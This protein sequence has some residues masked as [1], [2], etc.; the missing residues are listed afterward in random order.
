MPQ[1]SR[2][3]LKKEAEEKLLESL[4][5]LFSAVSNKEEMREFLTALMTETEKLMLAKRVGVIVLIY[6]G[7]NDTQIAKILNLTRITVSKIRYFYESRGLK[8]YNIMLGKLKQKERLENLKE[9]LISI[10]K[11][12]MEMT[13]YRV[14]PPRMEGS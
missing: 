8:G 3:K 12:G 2:I 4:D 14:K 5:H 9:G 1:V 11:L 7:L 13:K 10:A 6:H